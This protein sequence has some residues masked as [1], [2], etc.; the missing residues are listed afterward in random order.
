MLIVDDSPVFLGTL[1]RI[2]IDRGWPA[3]AGARSAEEALAVLRLG[4]PGAILVDLVMPGVS[5]FDLIPQLREQVP[6]AR[7]VAITTDPQPAVRRAALGA[8]AHAFVEKEHLLSRL[9]TVLSMSD[10]ELELAERAHDTVHEEDYL[11]R[12]ESSS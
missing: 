12:S 11:R 2:L 9:E 1:M 10:A 7:I 5:G 4:T 3:V 8:G 6:A